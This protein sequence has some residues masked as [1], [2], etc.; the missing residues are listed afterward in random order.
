MNRSVS[1]QFTIDSMT[2]TTTYNLEQHTFYHEQTVGKNAT[3]GYVK[4]ESLSKELQE[5]FK[6]LIGDGFI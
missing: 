4:F 5:C 6:V 2:A 3:A 1:I